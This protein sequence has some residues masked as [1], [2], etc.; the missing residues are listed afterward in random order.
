MERSGKIVQLHDRNRTRQS[1]DMWGDEIWADGYRW[2][3]YYNIDQAGSAM[4]NQ[5]AMEKAFFDQIKPGD[6]VDARFSDD[7][8]KVA[9]VVDR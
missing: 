9:K 5:D 1:V 2:I 6:Y 4:Q 3:I 7:D 8:W